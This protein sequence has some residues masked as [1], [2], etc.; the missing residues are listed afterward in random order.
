MSLS[1]CIFAASD[2]FKFSV[3]EGHVEGAVCARQCMNTL[4]DMNGLQSPKSQICA[5]KAELIDNLRYLVENSKQ[6]FNPNYRLRGVQF[7]VVDLSCLCFP[8]ASLTLNLFMYQF[9]RMLWKLLYH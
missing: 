1:A 6:H 2:S 5:D 7:T 4:T 9:V 8:S 3:A